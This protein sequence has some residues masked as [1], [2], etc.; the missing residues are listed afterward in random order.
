VKYSST[1]YEVIAMFVDIGTWSTMVELNL[2]TN[3]I[4]KLPEDIA[5]LHSLEVTIC[6]PFNRCW[7]NRISEFFYSSL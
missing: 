2:G 5:L 4:S 1:S 7:A 6:Q 3:Q